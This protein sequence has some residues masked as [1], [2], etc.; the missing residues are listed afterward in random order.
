MVQEPRFTYTVHKEVIAVRDAGQG[1][2]VSTDIWHVFSELERAG[3]DLGTYEIVYQN[4]RGIWGQLVVRVDFRSL[5][6]I[7]LG[8]ALARLG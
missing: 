7:D 1:P 6:E 5:D 2:S 8:A 4:A 3:Y